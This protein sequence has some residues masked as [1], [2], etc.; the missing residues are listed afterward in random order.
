MPTAEWCR[1]GAQMGEDIAEAFDA[2][3][4]SDAAKEERLNSEAL[5]IA[6][7]VVEADAEEKL[8]RIIA[9]ALTGGAPAGPKSIDRQA[10]RDALA[11]LRGDGR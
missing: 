5:R 6:A 8:A 4:A 10:A 1:D 7:R 3:G 2:A 11:Y 9:K